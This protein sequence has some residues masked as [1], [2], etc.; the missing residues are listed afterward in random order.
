[1]VKH[2][3]EHMRDSYY[4]FSELCVTQIFLNLPRW[5]PA[6]RHSPGQ[7]ESVLWLRSVPQ[8]PWWQASQPLVYNKNKNS[9]MFMWQVFLSVPPRHDSLVNPTETG[10]S[11]L[12]NVLVDQNCTDLH[13]SSSKRQLET[14][15]KHH[16]GEIM[17]CNIS[18][19]PT[20][21]FLL[22]CGWRC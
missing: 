17:Q 20:P 14:P 6:T 15:L 21:S 5:P 1:M 9:F 13:S 22:S 10:W 19:L 2:F 11:V 18:K 7:D 4:C 3:S 16:N 12:C 8:Q